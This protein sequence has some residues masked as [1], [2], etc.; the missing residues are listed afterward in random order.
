M[1]EIP[2]IHIVSKQRA[3]EILSDERAS[4]YQS[5]ISIG[6]SGYD[7]DG[8]PE[9]FSE[10]SGP[11]LRLN[12][13]DVLFVDMP[14]ACTRADIEKLVEFVPQITGQLLVHCHAGLSRSPAAALIVVATMLGGR[15]CGL[16][17]LEYFDKH[18]RGMPNALMI[19]HADHALGCVGDL[20][21]SLLNS[22]YDKDY[23]ELI[24]L[25]EQTKPTRLGCGVQ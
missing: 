11:K 24:S 17:T 12:I 18:L 1:K 2:T 13:N 22:F 25:H 23:P 6:W 8:I 20:Y 19:A 9:N 7:F 10:F 3:V 14:G 15:D 4:H 5:L 16:K 21:F